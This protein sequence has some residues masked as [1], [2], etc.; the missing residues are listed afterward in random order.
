[1]HKLNHQ[2]SVRP[3]HVSAVS[4]SRQTP[5]RPGVLQYDV[6]LIGGQTITVTGAAREIEE[7]L[8]GII[9]AIDAIHGA[10]A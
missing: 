4:E 8:T 1:M 3:D 6:F 7:S 10:Q 9:R 2:Y 5:G